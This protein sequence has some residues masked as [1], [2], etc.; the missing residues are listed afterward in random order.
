MN[1]DFEFK[2]LLHAF[3]AGIISEETFET[4]MATLE[5]G[6]NGGRGFTA[7][8]KTYASER[9]AIV[10]NVDRF[11]AGESAA[12]PAFETWAQQCTT[13]CI[14]SGLRMIAERESYHGRI[15]EQRMRDLGAECKAAPAEDSLKFHAA[16]K[17]AGLSDNEKL[18]KF[19]ARVANVEETFRPLQAFA[20]SI[21]DDLET[22]EAVKLFVE[23]EISSVK[24]LKNA[25]AVLNAP[26]QVGTR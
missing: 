11:R 3:R 13:D 1:R 2:Q 21:M 9:D 18:L 12:G 20:D 19:D 23:D 6:A 7:F 25:C 8:G 15:F 17:D 22:K 24:F 16:I 26:A 4:E 14:R 5:S 10:A